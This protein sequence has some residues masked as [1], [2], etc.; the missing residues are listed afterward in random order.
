MSDSTAIGNSNLNDGGVFYIVENSSFLITRVSLKNNT[1][2]NNGSA[3]YL[4]KSSTN[5]SY[6]KIIDCVIE[7][8][9]A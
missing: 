3:V 8:N 4:S 5:S 7:S 1:T 9:K 6:P 2:K